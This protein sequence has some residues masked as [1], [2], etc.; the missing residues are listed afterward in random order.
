M[1]VCTARGDPNV[2]FTRQRYSAC[3]AHCHHR[4]TMP[5]IDT[6]PAALDDVPAP[7]QVDPATARHHSRLDQALLTLLVQRRTATLATRDEAGE[8]A[9][10]LVPYAIDTVEGTL[11]IHV[12]A[13]AAHTRQ[14]R[15]HA[16]TS[17]LVAEGE[18]DGEPVLALQRLSLACRA[19]SLSGDSHGAAQAREIYLRRFP[20][21]LPLTEMGDFGF[22]RLHLLGARQVAG[23]GAARS[24]DA[25]AMRELL[26][27]CDVVNTPR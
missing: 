26:R 15:A 1:R 24:L 9:V 10:S 6:R 19:Q 27:H 3:I 16:R 18:V 12:S 20:E 13:L 8:P 2:A 11:L 7:E 14:L 22:W 23:F 21:A 17:L 25:L 5:V 4:K